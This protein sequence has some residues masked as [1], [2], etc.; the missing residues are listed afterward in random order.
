MKT[1]KTSYYFTASNPKELEDAFRKIGLSIN[2]S[3]VWVKQ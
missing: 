1:D 3:Q 2:T